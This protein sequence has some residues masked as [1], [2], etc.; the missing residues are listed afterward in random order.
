MTAERRLL[1]EARNEAMILDV[2]H[3]F[4]FQG[5]FSTAIAEGQLVVV[6]IILLVV[7][8]VSHVFASSFTRFIYILIEFTLVST[9]CDIDKQEESFFYSFPS[10]LIYVHNGATNKVLLMGDAK[11]VALAIHTTE[12]RGLSKA[13]FQKGTFTA[14]TRRRRKPKLRAANRIKL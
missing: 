6:L 2:V 10:S 8:L 3:V 7:L 1:K 4:L 12:S 5:A 11:C 14:R 13:R 9:L